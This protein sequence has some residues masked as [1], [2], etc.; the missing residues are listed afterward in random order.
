LPGIK[1]IYPDARIIGIPDAGH[2]L[3]AEQP[4]KFVEAVLSVV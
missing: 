2:W 3:H 1:A 4:E